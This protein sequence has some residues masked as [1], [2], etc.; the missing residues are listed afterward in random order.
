MQLPPPAATFRHGF[1]LVELS[2]MLVIIGLIAGGIL[3]GRHLVRVTE[4]TSVLT[5]R[6]AFIRGVQNFREKYN[7]LP[8]DMAN[9]TSFWGIAGGNSGDNYTASCR[10]SSGT[11]TQTCNG[12]GDG[13]IYSWHNDA[14][15]W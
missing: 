12:N 8:G 7:A 14:G 6:Q 4:I 13:Q 5:D 15:C 10:G 11:G 1:T 2:I 3:V 9:A